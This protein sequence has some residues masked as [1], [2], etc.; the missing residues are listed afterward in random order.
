MRSLTKTEWAQ[1]AACL[2]AAYFWAAVFAFTARHGGASERHIMVHLG[3]V[4]LFR[5]VPELKN[6]NTQLDP[7]NEE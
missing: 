5:E 2:A 3:S 7:H 6:K 4:L 1:C